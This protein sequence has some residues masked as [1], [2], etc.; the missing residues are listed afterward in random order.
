MHS[1]KLSFGSFLASE[2][3]KA[4]LR[5]R[6][7]VDA[8]QNLVP[9]TRAKLR[10]RALLAPEIS[11][12]RLRSGHH[13]VPCVHVAAMDGQHVAHAECSALISCPM[14]PADA[15]AERFLRDWVR[16]PPLLP[17]CWPR[18]ASPLGPWRGRLR[19][20]KLSFAGAAADAVLGKPPNAASAPIRARTSRGLRTWIAFPFSLR[21]E[22]YGTRA[23]PS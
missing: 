15:P 20:V 4:H 21:S 3:G 11:C 19:R 2:A 7:A 12:L 13:A 5:R 9:G 6:T 16:Q 17:P 10:T 18:T 14:K 23:L 22:A 8:I 1:T